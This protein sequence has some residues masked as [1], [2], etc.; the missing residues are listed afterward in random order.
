MAHIPKRATQHGIFLSGCEVSPPALKPGQVELH[1]QDLY[2]TEAKPVKEPYLFQ[3]QF[4]DSHYVTSTGRATLPEDYE[5]PTQAQKPP[6]VTIGGSG[7]TQHWRSEYKAALNEGKSEEAEFGRPWFPME[8]FGDPQ[9]LLTRGEVKSTYHEEFGKHGSNPRDKIYQTL[10][11]PMDAGTTK[12]TQHIP[13]YQGFVPSA[14]FNAEVARVEEGNFNRSVDKTNIEEIFHTNVV[15]YAGH[16]P[17]SA[18]NDNGG[19]Q[20]TSRTTAGHDFVDPVTRFQAF[21]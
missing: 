6:E 18:L 19:R 11:K 15:G 3:D 16:A 7:G 1:R 13:G 5:N 21:R 12:G 4:N 10:K 2:S 14:A 8:N 17:S 20:P 9:T